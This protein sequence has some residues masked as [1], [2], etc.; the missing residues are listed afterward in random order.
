[1]Q[2]LIAATRGGAV[3]SGRSDAGTIERGKVADIIIVDDD[4]LVE[5]DALRNVRLVIQA[6]RVVVER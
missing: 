1:M 6:G 5:F 2:V 4:P 3:L